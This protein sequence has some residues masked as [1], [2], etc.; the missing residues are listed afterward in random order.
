MAIASLDDYI[1]SAKQL[2]VFN[3][4]AS[5]VSVAGN[6]FSVVD[7]AGTPGAGTITGTNTA[8]GLVPV[9]ADIGYPTLQ[10][11]AP[12]AK[13]YITRFNFGSTVACRLR[14]MDLVFQ[15]GAYNFNSS[16]TLTA[17]PTF[18]SRIPGLDYKNLRIFVET[19]TAFTGTPIVT[20]GYTNSDGVAGRSTGAVNMGAA[21]TLGRMEPMSLQAGDTGV[22]KIESVLCTGATGG[23]FNVDLLRPLVE[24][25]VPSVGGG[26]VQDMLTTGLPEI[27]AEAALFFVVL[28]DSTATGIPYAEVEIGSF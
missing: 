24:G 16:V 22:S 27:T 2:R 21:L 15:A 12:G 28:P 11:F 7:L 23:T 19:V 8:N 25:R 17:Q 1:A 10:A 3:K 18:A 13:G 6:A 26:G 20:I 5:R 9:G 14:V 4:I